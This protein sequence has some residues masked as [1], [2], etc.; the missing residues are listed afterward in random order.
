MSWEFSHLLSILH[1]YVATRDVIALRIYCYTAIAGVQPEIAL[2]KLFPLGAP[3]APLSSSSKSSHGFHKVTIGSLPTTFQ[4]LHNQIHLLPCAIASPAS[5][6]ECLFVHEPGTS[7]F[8]RVAETQL[9]TTIRGEH[10]NPYLCATTNW[11]WTSIRMNSRWNRSQCRQTRCIVFGLSPTSSGLQ[12]T[13]TRVC[14]RCGRNFW[15]QF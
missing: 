7:L 9:A 5:S 12:N 15:W 14:Q 1:T 3:L 6:L 4:E 8:S 13:Q 2:I 10:A 11:K